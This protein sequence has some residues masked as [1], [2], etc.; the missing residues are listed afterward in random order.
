VA[1]DTPRTG[2]HVPPDQQPEMGHNFRM[3]QEDVERALSSGPL[4]L[5][6][7][8]R[9]EVFRLRMDASGRLE[10][11]STVRATAPKWVILADLDQNGKLRLASTVEQSHV[12]SAPGR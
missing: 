5:R 8:F 9:S 3:F 11:A 4:Y 10:V 12:F 2:V 7:Q 1:G 6:N